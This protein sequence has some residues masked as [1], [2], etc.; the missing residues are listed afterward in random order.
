MAGYK[1]LQSFLRRNPEISVRK[2]ENVSVARSVGMSKERVLHYFNLLDK[3]LA[4]NNL[5]DK[6]GNIYNADE[7][8]LQLNTRAGVVLAEKGSRNVAAMSSAEKG[9]TISVLTCCSAEGVFIPPYCVFK[10]KNRKDEWLDGMPPGSAINMSE[11]SAYVNSDIFF[12]WLRTHFYPRKMPGKVLLIVDGH[13]SHTNDLE[14]LQFAEENSII[15]LCLP[16]HTTHYLQPL[17]RAFFK[18]LKTHFYDAC[19]RFVKTN[20]SRKITRLQFGE[21]LGQAWNKSATVENAT[22]A[23]RSTGIVPFNSDAIPE[24]AF[25]QNV[26]ATSSEQP[27]ILQEQAA[28]FTFQPAVPDQS[29]PSFVTSCS[30][31]GPSEQPITLSTNELVEQDSSQQACKNIPSTSDCE[32]QSL[33]QREATTPVKHATKSDSAQFQDVM[34]TPGKLL[35]NIS[36]ITPTIAKVSRRGKNVATI[37]N[38]VTNIEKRRE[39]NLKK[40]QKKGKGTGTLKQT[41]TRKRVQIKKDKRR[42]ARS[43]SSSSTPSD[44]VLNDS[45]EISDEDYENECAG[46]KEDYRKTKRTEDWI[47]CIICGRWMHESCTKF[48]SKCPSCGKH[49]TETKAILSK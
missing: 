33:L 5:Y 46:C 13:S 38:S 49:E 20:P 29:Q 9:E 23:F 36:P 3:I 30:E 39:L 16:S 24:Y 7:T 45:P 22:A 34:E 40:K 32:Q 41:K 31:P 6:P 48:S 27:N 12:N 18:S 19:N 15:L 2:A 11:K 14:M 4:D 35:E 37:L 26:Q 44:Y 42:N 17:D 47:Q 10:G 43:S 1:W 25:I 8:G 28:T 21:L